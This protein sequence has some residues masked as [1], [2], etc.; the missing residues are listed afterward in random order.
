MFC[1]KMLYE[2]PQKRLYELK[3][4]GLNPCF[5]GKC[6]TSQKCWIAATIKELVLILVLLENALRACSID[7][8]GD[9]LNS[10]NPCFVGKCSTRKKKQRKQRK[11]RKSL[12]P[13]FVGKCSTSQKN[14]DYE[15]S[16]GS[17]LNPCFVGKCSTR[18]HY[19]LLTIIQSLNRS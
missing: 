15:N 5:V 17:S 2:I 9:N 13:C 3:Q 6:S 19:E 16:K 18:R 12:N 8:L 14:K 10:L 11:E 1:W 7:S 4:T